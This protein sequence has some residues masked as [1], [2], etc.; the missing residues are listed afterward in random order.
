LRLEI[1]DW[2][3]GRLRRWTDRPVTFCIN[4]TFEEERL[5][6]PD[7]R[8]S[9]G[10]TRIQVA[11][12]PTKDRDRRRNDVLAR[13]RDVLTSFRSYLMADEEQQIPAGGTLTRVKQMIAP[14]LARR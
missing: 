13:A 11:I 9:S 12:A 3:R 5:H 10:V 1:D 8:E 7:G 6:E 2:D 4:L 14:W